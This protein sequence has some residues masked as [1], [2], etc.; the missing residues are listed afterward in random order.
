MGWD[1]MARHMRQI[2]A[3]TW[4]IILVVGSAR[5]ADVKTFDDA[6]LRAVQFVDEHEGWAVGDL[7][8]IWHTIDG[9]KSWQRQP[10]GTRATL[11][12]IQ[13]F[14]FRLGWIGGRESVPFNPGSTG[15]LLYTRDGG[16]RWLLTSRQD[17]SGIHKIQFFGDDR[18]W[19]MGESTDQ[20]PGG[21]F[22]TED[23]GRRWKAWTGFRFPGW[24]TAFFTDFEHGVL[25]G[26][27]GSFSNLQQGVVLKARGDWLG[28]TTVRD[29]VESA[30]RIWAVGD[31]A[32]MYCSQDGGRNW[33]RVDLPVPAELRPYFHLRGVAAVGP[34]VW[35][36]GRPGSVVLHSADAGKTWSAQRTGSPIPLNDVQF[37]DSDHGWAV[38]EMGTILATSDGGR[39]WTA[40]RGGNQQAA[41]LWIAGDA[42]QIPL[43]AVARLGGEEGY[44]NVAFGVVTPDFKEGVP[45]VGSRPSRFEEGFRSVGGAAAETALRFPL[46]NAFA[47]RSAAEL[48]QLWDPLHEGRAEQNLLQ[49]LVL[50]I[51]LWSP[52]V[53]VTAGEATGSSF[54]ENSTLENVV[55]RLAA[56]AYR[57]A[58]NKEIFPEQLTFFGLKEHQA[59]TFYRRAEP[60][61]QDVIR[62]N[63]AEFGTRLQES[64]VDAAD[65]GMALIHEEYRMTEEGVSFELAD[66]TMKEPLRR[67]N[68]LAGAEASPGTAT[69]RLFDALDEFDITEAEAAARRK[70]NMLAILKLPENVIVPETLL[71]NLEKATDGMN[72][73]QAGQVMFQVGR[74]YA[75]MG[76]WDLACAVFEGMIESQPQHPLA[77]EAH[78]WLIAYHASAEA[79]KRAELPADGHFEIATFTRREGGGESAG[80]IERASY[81]Q[82]KRDT[83]APLKAA[84]MAILEGNRLRAASPHVWSDPRVQLCLL[85]ANRRLGNKE[86]L[87]F[88]EGRI[89]ESDPDSRW[90]PAIQMEKWLEGKLETPPRSVAWC[91]LTGERPYLDGKLEEAAWGDAKPFPIQSGNEKLDAAYKTTVRFRYDH[92]H[93]YVAVDCRHPSD[94]PK[95]APVARTGHDADL[96]GHDRIEIYLDIDRDYSTF[97]RFAVDQRGLVAEDCWGDVSWNPKWFV[98][99]ESNEEGWRVEIAI[100]LAELAEK[101]DLTLAA[102]AFN[103]S[104]VVPGKGLFAFSRPAGIAPR[105]DGFSILK[106]VTR[107]GQSL[108]SARA[109]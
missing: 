52:R 99:T 71:A 105:P 75:G 93:L 84:G 79:L 17:L 45:S 31:Q 18:G 64:Y 94:T 40:Q 19:A 27:N 42:R 104:R 80:A 43:T 58:G 61:K 97:Y 3:W 54:V 69:R 36:V 46:A 74:R 33:S 78:R 8:T 103:V 28:N 41:L 2:L 96:S 102:W 12:S 76:R 21:L 23:G 86:I 91:A 77:P 32:Q 6:A 85:A 106:F 51:R 1:T 53:L 24:R 14:D 38:G 66:S 9:G 98:A 39:T 63:G 67:A 109:N 7:G 81:R 34:S 50:A 95:V 25:G 30:G 101:Q 72:V 49:E 107:D 48:W 10:S 83:E 73:M 88:H 60:S 5:G 68:L 44:Y 87:A 15:Q 89:V 35:V 82:V 37:V 59:V 22:Y 70:T 55:A 57:D 90:A 108:K 11:T 13:M 29:I 92:E 20:D 26:V 56:K 47:G 62:L 16:G 65:A 4:F 100:P